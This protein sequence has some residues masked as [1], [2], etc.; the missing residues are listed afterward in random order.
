M[1]STIAKIDLS[2]MGVTF[3]ALGNSIPDMM[4]DMSVAKMGFPLMGITAT[5]AGPTFNVMLGL[6]ISFLVSGLRGKIPKPTPFKGTGLEV[7][8]AIICALCMVSELFIL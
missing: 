3:M 8:I 4:T 5:I 2:Y 1:V 6:G 7:S